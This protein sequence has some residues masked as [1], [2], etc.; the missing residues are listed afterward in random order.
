[1]KRILSDAWYKNRALN[2]GIC[3]GVSLLGMPDICKTSTI[4]ILYDLCDRLPASSCI[5]RNETESAEYIAWLV[6]ISA[7]HIAADN[8]S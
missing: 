8:S 1:M 3:R 6:L 4:N 7:T 2:L 5:E